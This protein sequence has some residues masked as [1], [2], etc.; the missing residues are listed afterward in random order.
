M[1]PTVATAAYFAVIVWLLQR[2]S[3]DGPRHSPALWIPTVWFGIM[4]SKPVIYWFGE[5]RGTVAM[6]NYIDGSP[7]DRNVHLLLLVAAAVALFRRRVGWHTIFAARRPVWIFYA[8][9]ALSIA[10][11]DH[12]YVSFKRYIRDIGHIVMALLILTDR[13]PMEAV[14]HV[15]VRCTVALIPLS[16]LTIK[17]YPDVGRYYHRWTD[18]VL[19]AGVTTT[20]NSLGV[21]AMLG[22]LFMVWHITERASRGAPGR[23]ARALWPEASVL[24]ACVWLVHLANS[25][26]ATACLLLGAVLFFGARLTLAGRDTKWTVGVLTVAACAAGLA[27]W[28]PTVRGAVAQGLGRD[29][30]LTT[31]TDIWAAVFDLPT[32]PLFGAGFAS[33][34]LTPEGQALGLALNIPHSHN[35]Y[36]ETYLNSGAIGL[37]LLLVVLALAAT[38]SARVLRVNATAGAFYV[39]MV[40]TGAVYNFSEPTFNN[41]H[42]FGVLIFLIALSPPTVGQLWA[43]SARPRTTQSV[44]KTLWPRQRRPL[45]KQLGRGTRI[46]RSQGARGSVDAG[47]DG[48]GTTASTSIGR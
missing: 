4:L 12:P 7:I 47:S 39:A 38:Q 13:H 20:K 29:P 21:L 9:L 33:V 32:E 41:G 18:Q 10:W 26:T 48:A 45:A 36:A 2:I 35:G 37:A 22:G 11:S 34:W 6:A 40:L 15:F 25:A 46:R 24:L 31:R 44:R 5:Q 16:L 28:S 27:L 42:A 3:R 14:R 17:Y 43:D 19:Y 1:P 30:T 8:Y 23:R